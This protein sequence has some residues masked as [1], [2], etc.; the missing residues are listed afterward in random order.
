MLA[1][2]DDPADDLAAH[3]AIAE[4]PTFADQGDPHLPARSVPGAG[5]RRAG[6]T[7]SSSSAPRPAVDVGDYAG[8][9]A[10]LED[11]RRYFIAHGATSADHS[12]L[13]AG[14]EPLEPAE[15]QRIYR[16]ALNG[17]ATADGGHRV[18]P[19]H[20][21]GDGP[22]VLRRRAGDDPA[23]GGAPQSP[24]GHLR[25]VR[26]GHR[27][28]HPGGRGVHQR[29]AA[30]AG[31]VRHP[32]QPAPGAVHPRRRRL[33]PGDR[34]AGR[35]LPVGVRRRPWWF[36]D[37]PSEIRSFQQSV[38]EIAGLS[39]LSGFIDDTRAFCSIPARHDMSR[40]LDAGFLAGLVAEHRLDEDEA[41]DS[42]TDLVADQPRKVFK[43]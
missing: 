7:R 31:A 39:R 26:R 42:I 36:L 3:A 13:D 12:H 25:P 9:I 10:A 32:S 27:A 43:L 2:T 20:G 28:R 30:A 19:A 8:Y 23:P 24:P 18:P 22:D 29:A 4:D 15:A 35:V 17:R 21:A 5:A 6:P 40:R 41:L 1:T 37:N 38:T 11:R 33:Q 14:A 34:P 16:L